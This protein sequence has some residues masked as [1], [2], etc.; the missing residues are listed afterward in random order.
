MELVNVFNP[1]KGPMKRILLLAL[2]PF[3]I[4]G[5]GCATHFTKTVSV[6]KDAN[7]KIIETIETESVTQPGRPGRPIQFEHIKNQPY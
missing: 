7:G 6:K 2:F 3:L 1:A 4:L 5:A